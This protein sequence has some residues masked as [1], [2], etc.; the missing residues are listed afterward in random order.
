M[1]ELNWVDFVILIV[2]LFYAIEG[3]FTGFIASLLDLVSFVVSFTVGLKY[4][5]VVGSILIET[6]SITQGFSNAIGFFIVAFLSEIV[7]GLIMRK[8]LNRK[9]LATYYLKFSV[10]KITNKFL[11]I[12]PGI[13]SGLVLLA[14][15]LTLVVALPLSAFIK[16]SVTSSKVGKELVRKTQGFEKELNNVFG[17]AVS[18]TLNFLTVAPQSSERVDLH[19]QVRNFSIDRNSEQA[20]LV[21]VNQERA[22]QGIAQVVFDEQLAQVGRNHCKDMFK[23]G[24]FSHNTLESLSPFDRMLNAGVSFTYA[25]ENLALAPDVSLAMQGLMD[26]R[27]HRENILSPNF[28]KLGVGVIDGGLYGKMFCQEFTD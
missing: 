18:E 2:L 26:S 16:Q 24:Y 19:F 25:G 8:F 11:G 28:G 12:V 14:F 17:G 9:I 22:K 13:F 4:Y 7:I 20:M 10:I 1:N 15:L 27:G 3:Y 6:F 5:A 23:R 21:V